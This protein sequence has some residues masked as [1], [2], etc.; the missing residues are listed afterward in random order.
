MCS[1]LV[2]NVSRLKENQSHIS[3]NSHSYSLTQTHSNPKVNFTSTRPGIEENKTVK[4]Q[5][6]QDMNDQQGE[7]KTIEKDR[8]LKTS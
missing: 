3:R 5:N 1:I 2:D 7:F 8:I 6:S 4:L